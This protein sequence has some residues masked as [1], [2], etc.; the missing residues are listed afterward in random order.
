MNGAPLYNFNYISCITS[1]VYFK[2][3]VVV[4]FGL[5]IT[6]VDE[7]DVLHDKRAFIG[8]LIIALLFSWTQLEELGAMILLIVLL[9]LVYNIQYTKKRIN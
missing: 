7:I 2:F 8:L 4:V 6:F 5:V 9:M 1:N 3:L